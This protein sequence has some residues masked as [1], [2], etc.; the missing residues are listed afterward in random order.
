MGGVDLETQKEWSFGIGEN[1][2]PHL[3]DPRVQDPSW[4]EN[5]QV[6]WRMRL[7]PGIR[8]LEGKDHRCVFFSHFQGRTRYEGIGSL[9][10]NLLVE[11]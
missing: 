10:F 4:N 1:T 3:T 9:I 11:C 5:Q 8:Q 7:R 6:S 2:A